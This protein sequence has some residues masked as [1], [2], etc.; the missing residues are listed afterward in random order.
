MRPGTLS[1]WRGAQRAAPETW[2]SKEQ[3]GGHLGK[4]PPDRKGNRGSPGARGSH[5]ETGRHPSPSQI[6]IWTRAPDAR[7]YLDPNGIL[8]LD[9]NFC[10]YWDLTQG[11]SAIEP[12]PGP[13]L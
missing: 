5:P 10:P 7:C 2:L 4:P 3:P 12:H 1:S 6:Q 13:F 9:P 8:S 11:C